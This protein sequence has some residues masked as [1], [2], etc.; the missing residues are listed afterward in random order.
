MILT[1]SKEH[2]VPVVRGRIGIMD[3]DAF[4]AESV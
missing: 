1:R 4:P 3:A 2:R